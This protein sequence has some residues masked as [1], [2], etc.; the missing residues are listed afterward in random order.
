MMRR[1]FLYPAAVAAAALAGAAHAEAQ[2]ITITAADGFMFIRCV[3]MFGSASCE[4]L[5]DDRTGVLN[6]VA[7]DADSRPI[8]SQMS[9]A[10][11]GQVDF[12]DLDF[13]RVR[14]VICRR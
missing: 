2:G 10:N 5:V 14:D 7:F 3:D 1:R 4:Y 9:L 12:I 8:A 11:T 6:C 13:T